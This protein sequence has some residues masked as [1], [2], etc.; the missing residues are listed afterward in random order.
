MIKALYCDRKSSTFHELHSVH[1]VKAKLQDPNVLLWIDLCDPNE[2]E[3]KHLATSFR[4]HPLAVEDALQEHQRPKI[5]EYQDFYFMVFYAVERGSK[6]NTIAFHEID[7][8]LNSHYLI[9]VHKLPIAAFEEV[10]QRW[11][12]NTKLL[13]A[14]IGI[15]LYSF[16]DTVVDSYFPIID[17]LVDEAEQIEDNLFERERPNRHL[18]IRLLSLRKEF[19]E[20][21]RIVTPQRDVLNTLTN[22][23]NP[24]H[25][26]PQV[27]VY[28]RDI[29]DHI[30]RLAE[31]IDIYRDQLNS[32][33][34][35]NLTIASNELNKV[36]RTMTAASIIL[37]VDS[38][39]AG[40]YGMNFD[41]MPEL[42]FQWAYFV[43]LGFMGILT[44]ILIAIFRTIHWL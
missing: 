41:Y 36:M 34:D 21:R 6:Q 27:D 38:L 5:E 16:L 13:D 7:M 20:L 10:E 39:I 43:V 24:L 17:T 2:E 44:A 29:Y 26:N 37:M 19:L 28:F 22:R 8:F 33:M 35:T 18:T 25:E 4:L 32:V 1:A 9:T 31:T 40:I 30:T 23:D 15:L 14:G 42:H 12:R 11:T 3:I